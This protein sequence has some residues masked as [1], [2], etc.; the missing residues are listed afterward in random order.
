MK[1]ILKFFK[2]RWL[3]FFPKENGA[4]SNG[5]NREAPRSAK[6]QIAWRGEYEIGYEP[7]DTQ[8]KALLQ[9]IMKLE[10]V[11]AND[12][13]NREAIVTALDEITQYALHHFKTEEELMVEM[14]YPDIENHIDQHFAF[15][16]KSIKFMHDA[17]QGTLDVNK[18]LSFMQS[19]WA[20]HVLQEDFAYRSCIPNIYR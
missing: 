1:A 18:L 7:I 17:L 15:T 20:A 4:S 19:W 5:D 13:D 16:A 3:K 14:A 12:R 11:V 2:E 10:T 6:S 9:T 8:H